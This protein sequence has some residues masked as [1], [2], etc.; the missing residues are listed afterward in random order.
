MNPGLFLAN[1]G[2]DFELT[3][4]VRLISNCNL[5]WFDQT[6]PLEE[7]TFQSGIHKH[8]GTDLSLGTEYRPYLNNNRIHGESPA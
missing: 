8:I 3:Q 4:K 1:F 5:L 6:A 2:M 7:I